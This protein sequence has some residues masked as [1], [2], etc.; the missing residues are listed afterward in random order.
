MKRGLIGFLFVLVSFAL[1]S[2]A[3]CSDDQTIMKLYSEDN[4]HVSIWNSE[5]YDVRIC[6]DDVFG[7]P[8]SKAN[9][10]DCN[11]AN[12]VL[13][14]YN[15]S[16]SHASVSHDDNYAIDVCYGDLSCVYDNSSGDACSNGGE[17]VARLYSQTNSHVAVPSS[18]VYPWK[19]CCL[20]LGAYWADANGNKIAEADFGDTVQ[21][22]D[23]TTSSGTFIVKESDFLVDDDIR[24]IEG[25]GNDFGLVG[26]WTIQQ[27][28]LDKTEEDYD[29]FY[30]Y[31]EGGMESE[32]LKINPIGEDSVMD[33]TIVSPACGS[34]F[35]EGE[36]VN[37]SISASDDDNIIT[38][39]VNINGENISFSNGGVS[40]SRFFN[41]SGNIKVIAEASND[42]GYKSKVISNVMVLDKE[43]DSYV[44]GEYVA[45]C[46]DKPANFENIPGSRVDF[47]ASATRAIRVIGGIVDELIPG[48]DPFSWYW[49]FYPEGI[50]NNYINT[51]DMRAYKF[52]AEFPIAG[53][54]LASL[55]VEI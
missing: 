27:E 42:R 6:H 37:V 10:H 3:S 22:I 31:V 32:R 51:T 44:D 18:V 40:F 2:A 20:S 54:N 47:D 4:S 53:N 21:L 16:N 7:F 29:G 33:V 26:Y 34:H 9:P 12:R 36:E 45:A 11:G 35:D 46:I 41:V 23:R 30:F 14:L 8:Y 24:S 28:D 25:A 43:G 49:T 5:F 55:R 38:G 1:V 48:I 15:T 50:E 39:H 52:T 13:S 19:V 17:V